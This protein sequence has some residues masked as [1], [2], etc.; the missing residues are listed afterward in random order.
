MKK[1]LKFTNCVASFLLVGSLQ[2]YAAS[3]VKLQLN[4]KN[5]TLMEVLEEIEHQ[6]GY[7][8][9]IQ[10]NDLDTRKKISVSS[11]DESV[12]KVLSRVLSR[13]ALAHEIRDNHVVIV[14]KSQANTLKEYQQNDKKTKVSGVVVD[15]RGEPIIG[16]NIIIKGSDQGTISDL[17]GAFSLEVSTGD[18]LEISYIGYTTQRVIYKNQKSLDIVLLED[19]KTL[20]EVVVVGYGT[21]K[22]KDLTGSVGSVKGNVLVEQQSTQLSNAL[23]GTIP[24]VLV[25]RSNGAPGNTSSIKVR[26]ITTIGDS[27]PLII[28]DG[29]AVSSIDQVNPNDVENISV[30]KDAASASI[31]GARAAA[32]VVL[33]TTKRAKQDELFLNYNFEYGFEKPTQMP[34]FVG[35]TRYLEMT[36]ELR[37]NDAGN[38]DNQYPTYSKDIVDD[39][40]NLNKTDPDKYPITDWQDLILKRSAP[41]QRHALS[42]SAGSNV[43][44]TNVSLGYDRSDGLYADRYY[45]RITARANNDFTINKYIGASF[46][47]NFKRSKSHQPNYDPIH[48]MRVAAPVYAALWSD[49]R[50][51]EGKSG[52]NPYG[53]MRDGGTADNWYNQVGGKIGL[54]IKP[55]DGLKISGIIAPIYNFDKSKNHRKKVAYYSATD[56]NEFVGY[57]EGY[58]TTK[59][60]EGRSDNYSVTYQGIANYNKTIKSVHDISLMAGYESYYAFN[61]TLSASRDKYEL[62]NFPYLDLGPLELRDNGGRAWETA[63]QSWFGRVMY[64]YQNKYLLQANIRY[65]GSSRFHNKYRWGAFP[66]FSGGWV[67]T[68][69]NFLKPSDLLSFLKVRASWGTLGNERIGNY[70]YQS[71]IVFGNTLFYQNGDVLSQLTA[72]QQRYVI[73]SISWEKTES[74][75]IGIDANF[76]NNRLRFTG[77]YYIKTTKDMLLS[78]EIP[79]YIGFDNPDQNTG[80]MNTKGFEVQL[81]WSDQIGDIRYAISGN[82]SDFKSKMGD[83]GGTEF[84]GDQVKKKGSEFNEWYGYLTDGLFQT[85][86]EVAQSPVL[87]KNVK[88]GDLKYRDI[89]GPDGVP[90]GKISPDYDR[91][92]LGGSMPRFTYGGRLS[93]GYKG[94]DL[95]M[96]FQGVGKQNA[97]ISTMMMQPLRENWGNIPAL[98]D[99]NYWSQYNTD[100]QNQNAMYPR[101]SYAQAASNYAMSDYWLFSGR[102]FRLKNITLSY[103]I[104]KSITEKAMIDQLRVYVS[105]NDLFSIDKYPQGWDPEMGSSAYPITRSFMFGFSVNF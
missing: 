8:V 28:V 37:W 42:I 7:S 103:I 98:I 38:G 34:K 87:N 58:A 5:A 19:T 65:D 70:P 52:A 22:K 47:M 80:K 77:D 72:A 104:P 15:E 101:L 31:Y 32:G 100:E 64:S 35:V 105:A 4:F 10:T 43:V 33:I 20:E 74:F 49:G 54:D 40:L 97:R 44:K 48:R 59:L 79:D 3:D 60:T 39:Y 85:A 9:L 16:A 84:L 17:D 30:L 14:A 56:P 57:L 55:I 25:S 1:K 76:F 75:D 23:Q 61:E 86:E 46:D 83:L 24:G 90:D 18:Q 27:N 93:V 63:Y 62:D 91:V 53:L 26:G 21:M 82:V 11:R 45:E 88:P 12:D 92:L 96:T 69:E 66:S 6:T 36:N 73:E 71:T 94:L 50:I 78:L 81:D 2:V 67:I 99:G 68:E 13:F 29:V 89:S 51:A 95:S 102:Y 41:R